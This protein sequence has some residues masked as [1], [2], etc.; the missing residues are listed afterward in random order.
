MKFLI[1]ADGKTLE[2]NVA[3]RFGK[4]R[5]YLV[6]DSDTNDVE[7]FPNLKIDDHH[8]IVP[9]AVERGVDTVITGN[10]GPRSFE[11]ISFHNLRIALARNT[12]VQDAMNR[13][14]QGALRILDAPTVL[15]NLEELELFRKG[16]RDQSRKGSHS[17]RGKG[18]YAS[19]TPR[20][21]HHLQQYGGRGH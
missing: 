8:D 1:A 12:S 11:L 7:Q 19:A 9:K 15:K 5:W 3:K 20:G 6:V 10:V 4:A 21:Q 18:A 13:L 17:P 16:R 2:S 14:H